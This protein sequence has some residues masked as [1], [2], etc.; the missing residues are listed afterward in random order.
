MKKI[1]R[2]QIRGHRRSFE[3]DAIDGKKWVKFA[4]IRQNSATLTC[5]LNTMKVIVKSYLTEKMHSH[6]KQY[7]SKPKKKK[8]RKLL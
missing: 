3:I 2:K 4:A 6:S 7:I 8:K 5:D 1:L